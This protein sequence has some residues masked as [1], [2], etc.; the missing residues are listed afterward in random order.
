ME[1]K[2]SVSRKNSFVGK[3]HTHF[4]TATGLFQSLEKVMTT[5]TWSPILWKE[6]HRKKLNFLQAQLIALDFDSGVWTLEHAKEFF[7]DYQMNVIIGTTKSHQKEKTTSTG[8]VLPSCDRFRVIVGTSEPCTSLENYEHTMSEIMKKIPCD[9]SCKDGARFFYPCK[10]IVLVS[11]GGNNFSWEEKSE[12]QKKA[13]KR[14]E[15]FRSKETLAHRTNG[16]IPYN[17]KK[18]LV[19]GARNVDGKGRHNS[20]YVIGA[21]LGKIGYSEP[22][23]VACILKQNSNLKEIGEADVR[24]AVR[25]GIEKAYRQQKNFEARFA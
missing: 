15:E 23:I 16:T 9:K 10:D 5:R 22:E 19:E 2:I 25:N 1:V 4:N 11:E 20:C 12:E 18:L 21:E 17:I 13:E 6:G 8:A 24:R 3:D 14:T 7:L